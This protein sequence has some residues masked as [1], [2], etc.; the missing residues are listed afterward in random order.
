MTWWDKKE[1]SSTA[2]GT[3]LLKDIFAELQIFSY[4]KSLY[5][6][7]DSLRVMNNKKNAAQNKIGQ[8]VFV[9]NIV[10]DSLSQQLANLGLYKTPM[11]ST[12]KNYANQENYS[13]TNFSISGVG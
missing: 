6:V 2:Y 5:A 12:L 7:M 13:E 4:P 3:N 8:I 9:K 1:Y 11:L 10:S